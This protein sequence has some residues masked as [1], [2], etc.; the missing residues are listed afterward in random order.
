MM[1]FVLRVIADIDRL[2]RISP[3][4]IARPVILVFSPHYH[5]REQGQNMKIHPFLLYLYSTF[6]TVLF[7]LG[8]SFHLQIQK[9]VH[10]MYRYG[11]SLQID[12]QDAFLDG[13]EE[14]F[15]A[16]RG[17]SIRYTSLAAVRLDIFHRTELLTL[18]CQHFQTN[19]IG[20]ENSHP[21][22]VSP[23]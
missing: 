1:V 15:F 19:R 22:S 16:P 13:R 12:I 2:N 20:N 18:V 10:D 17:P 21:D 6:T 9:P 14:V 23:P 4:S 7:I 5:L 8:L 11:A 3:L